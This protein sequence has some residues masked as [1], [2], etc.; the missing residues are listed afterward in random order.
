[1]YEIESENGNEKGVEVS[2]RSTQSDSGV[3]VVDVSGYGDELFCSAS[4]NDNPVTG[5]VSD[6]NGT[7][8]SVPDSISD[9]IST[10]DSSA[11]LPSVSPGD[12]ETGGM[13][14][15]ETV[16]QITETL[17]YDD[18]VLVEKLDRLN[19]S[20]SLLLMAVLFAWTEK[21]IS[22]VTKRMGE[23]KR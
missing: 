23:R 18:S 17:V 4:G 11:V 21:K 9:S 19:L 10:G 3:V 22:V 13:G 20:V 6:G 2:E 14:T 1:M 5:T 7:A 15:D 16:E 12:S 8:E